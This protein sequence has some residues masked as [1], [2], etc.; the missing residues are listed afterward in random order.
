MSFIYKL[1]EFF[2]QKTFLARS[3][4]LQRGVVTLLVFAVILFILAFAIMPKRVSLVL[5]RPSPQ[6][7]YAPREAIDYYTTTRLQEEAAAKVPE[8]FDFEQGVLAEAGVVVENF[9]DGVFSLRRE[10]DETVRGARTRTFRENLPFILTDTVIEALLMV[11]EAELLEMKSV[12]LNALHNTLEQGIK[13]AALDSAHVQIAEEIYRENLPEDLLPAAEFLAVSLVQPNLLYNPAAT[14]RAREEAKET[15][16]PVK[17]WPGALLIS[18]G[19]QVTQKHIS[20]LETLGLQRIGT[21]YIIFVGLVML[22]VLLFFI[23]GTYLSIYEKDI[24]RKP[25]YLFLLGLII[26][27]TLLF[28][29]AGNYFSGFLMPAAMG[30]ILISV[31]FNYRLALLTAVIFGILTGLITGGDFRFIL[32]TVLGGLVAFLAVFKVQRR[33]DLAKAGLY[34]AVANVVSIVGIFLFTGVA[35]L[36]YDFFREF[37][38]AVLSGIGSGF[39]SAIMAIGLLPYLESG[40]GLI[41]SVTLL[42]LADPSR[43]LL[44]R[45]LREAPGTYHHSIIVANLAESAAEAVGADPLLARVGAYY[46]DIGKLKRPY[47][48]AEN[49]MAQNN[50][51]E[52]IS[53]NLSTLIIT[54]HIK[55]G[56]ELAQKEKLPRVIRDIIQQHHGTSLVSYFYMQAAGDNDGR[57]RVEEINFRY[58]GPKPASKE[59]A[60]VSLADSVEATVRSMVKP[61]AGKVEGVVRKIMRDKLNDGQLD[62]SNLTLGEVNDIADTFVHMLAGIFHTRI[63]YPEKEFKEIAGG[64]END[65]KNK[66]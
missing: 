38:I 3:K 62:E 48:F 4:N 27:L 39:F 36:E 55:D 44:K 12:V 15:I 32:V 43:N 11:E 52:K 6:T 56:L 29:V 20:Q 50:P 23:V 58:E 7:I 2:E 57:E 65:S 30:I 37:S 5:G 14:T 33:D 19:E 54:S 66:S 35:R 40:F 13:P 61:T 10:E 8:T 42:E 47:F 45:L 53:A 18:A 60:I 25:S 26:A 9:F 64:E 28:A 63:E 51:H 41:T 1:G 49:Q 46:H 34:V 31:L 22:L 59:A 24:F 16:E 17:I 21:D